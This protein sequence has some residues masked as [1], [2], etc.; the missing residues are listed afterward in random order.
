MQ[1]AS[2]IQELARYRGKKGNL[3]FPLAEPL[4]IELIGRVALALS[5]EYARN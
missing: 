1:D 2:L 3:S 5:H 4:P